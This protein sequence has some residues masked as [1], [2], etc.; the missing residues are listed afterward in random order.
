MGS[1]RGGLPADAAATWDPRAV[2]G[3]VSPSLAD[4]GSPPAWDTHSGCA[5]FAGH[6]SE[7]CRASRGVGRF[8]PPLPRLPPGSSKGI[9]ARSTFLSPGWKPLRLLI[10]EA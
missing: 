10:T 8:P 9:S 5:T 6:M 7:L 2:A 4:V 3:L 1:W